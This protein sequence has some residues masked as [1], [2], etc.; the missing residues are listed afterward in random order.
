MDFDYSPKVKELQARLNA[1]MD[2]HIYPNEKA[3]H[4]EIEANRAKGNPWVPTKI[5]EDMKEKARAAGL[6]NLFLA[7]SQYGA[8]LP[9]L[10][11][12]PLCATI[13]R[14]SHFDPEASN[15]DAPNTGNTDA[16]VS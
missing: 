13:A 8:G 10:D 1:F 14:S 6:W 12:A 16:L 5:M 11:S 7:E 3:F 15:S 2:Q 4:A 9:N